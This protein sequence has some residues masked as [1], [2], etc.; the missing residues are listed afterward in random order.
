MTD[1]DIE[2]MLVREDFPCQINDYVNL[3]FEIDGSFIHN[4]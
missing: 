3:Q 2:S 1:V 4:S